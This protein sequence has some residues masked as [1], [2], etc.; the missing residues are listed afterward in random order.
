[1]Y[2]THKYKTIEKTFYVS[3]LLWLCCVVGGGCGEKKKCGKY[4]AML[5]QIS[6]NEEVTEKVFKRI[7][8]PSLIHVPRFIK[9]SSCRGVSSSEHARR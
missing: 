5:V 8:K 2:F 4:L 1:M 7:P 6:C 3:V 9:P